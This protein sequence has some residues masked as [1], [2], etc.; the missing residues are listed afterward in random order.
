MEKLRFVH[1]SHALPEEPESFSFKLFNY[2]SDANDKTGL[3]H[4]NNGIDAYG[5]GIY[6][7]PVTP[8]YPSRYGQVQ[9]F[10]GHE[11]EGSVI[12][13]SLDLVD[14]YTEEF[15]QPAN[16]IPVDDI[17]IDDWGRAVTEFLVELS[18]AQG[19]DEQAFEND[20]EAL[21]ERW[22]EEVPPETLDS[23]FEDMKEAYP[24][25]EMDDFSPSEY[26][27]P[28]EWADAVRDSL[29]HLG[30]LSSIREEFGDGY[31]VVSVAAERSKTAWEM[32]MDIHSAVA[33]TSSGANGQTW[34]GLFQEVMLRELSEESINQ[35]TYANVNLDN[36]GQKTEYSF[37]VV[38]GTHK[39]DIDV[40]EQRKLPLD[41]SLVEKILSRS[42]EVI[43]E[44]EDS[45]LTL[46][47]LKMKIED[48]GVE[49]TGSPL[50]PAVAHEASMRR[51]DI[52][53]L[54]RVMRGTMATPEYSVWERKP[55]MARDYDFPS[56]EGGPDNIDNKPANKLKR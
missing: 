35:V 22:D 3:S 18:K 1:G 17:D 26:D 55:G 42:D 10:R 34:N 19:V 45:G 41:E 16:E 47:Q 5:P 4:I 24:G 14:Q 54:K 12:G 37:C 30:P 21:S 52:T 46:S 13:F 6:A 23:L 31:G 53:P 33:V 32:L 8:G 51:R 15:L 48:I 25:V 9:G 28:Y 50:P 36:E 40:I 49:I 29:Y 38:F 11:G 56:L 27:D 2:K 39:V 20:V 43:K 44:Y 7:F